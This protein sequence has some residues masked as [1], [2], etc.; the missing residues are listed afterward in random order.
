MREFE[1]LEDKFDP[2]YIMPKL[3]RS[4]P[5]CPDSLGFLFIKKIF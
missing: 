4:S 2:P 1:W 3:G 5:I